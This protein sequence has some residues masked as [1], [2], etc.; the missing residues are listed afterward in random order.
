MTEHC[1]VDAYDA[2]S[3]GR[4]AI[5]RSAHED[6]S[7]H[8]YRQ[9]SVRRIAQNAG[10]AVGTVYFHFGSKRKLYAAIA[11]PIEQSLLI[12]FQSFQKNERE[13]FGGVSSYDEAV[14][15]E[16]KLMC[17]MID[18]LISNREAI[19]LV[20][21]KGRGSG[22]IDFLDRVAAYFDRSNYQAITDSG[23]DDCESVYQLNQLNYQSYA[24]LQKKVVSGEWDR[25]RA[26]QIAE[27][28]TVF[29]MAGWNAVC[30]T[31]FPFDDNAFL[32]GNNDE[33]IR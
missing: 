20:S 24:C 17:E 16:K 3:P 25:Q 23:L 30:R 19:L 18:F 1:S 31:A 8:G 21:E 2:N 14:S 13:I 26:L 15:A 10:Y 22:R 29:Q 5:L 6:F 32:V 11:E 27:M 4:T 7:Q 9:A 33:S 28:F 12:G